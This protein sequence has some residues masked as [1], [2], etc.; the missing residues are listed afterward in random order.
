MRT[1]GTYERMKMKKEEMERINQ[2]RAH[3]FKWKMKYTLVLI[4]IFVV[5]LGKT[6]AN[7]YYLAPFKKIVLP[8]G[9]EVIKTSVNVTDVYG[10]HVNAEKLL[11]TD[12]DWDEMKENITITKIGKA[13][14]FILPVCDYTGNNHYTVEWDDYSIDTNSVIQSKGTQGKNYYILQVSTPYGRF[15]Y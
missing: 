7:A 2:K 13:R 4:V 10:W 11:E 8:D 3:K 6:L 1:K 15:T 12:L 5:L 9:V 14:Y